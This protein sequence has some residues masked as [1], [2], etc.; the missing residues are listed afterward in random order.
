MVSQAL[1]AAGVR[2]AIGGSTMLR[3]YGVAVAAGDVDVL[4]DATSRAAVERALPQLELLSAVSDPWRSSWMLRG[5]VATAEGEVAVDV[6]GGLAM[7]I[8]GRLVSFPVRQAAFVDDDGLGVPVA[9]PAEWYHLYSV[10][11]PAKAAAIAAVVPRE[12]I[13]AAG[14]RLGIVTEAL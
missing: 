6:I 4:V 1:G 12:D 14:R 11:D 2:F 13:E 3:L 9:S 7:M 8:G 10:Y 5:A